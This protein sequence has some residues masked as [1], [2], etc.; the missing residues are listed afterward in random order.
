V[1][2]SPTG[3]YLHDGNTRRRFYTT[4]AAAGLDHKRTADKPMTFHDLRHTFGTLAV[5]VWPLSDVQA[6]HGSLG[7]DDDDDDDV[8]HVPKARTWPMR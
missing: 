1:F 6:L 5:Q 7:R 8:H 2:I 3:G 4:L